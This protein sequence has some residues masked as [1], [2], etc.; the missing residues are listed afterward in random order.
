MNDEHLNSTDLCMEVT[1]RELKVG[2]RVDHKGWWTRVSR[3]DRDDDGWCVLLAEGSGIVDPTGTTGTWKLAPIKIEDRRSLTFRN[4][5]TLTFERTV[6]GHP[7]EWEYGDE[8]ETW[9]RT[10]T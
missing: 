7:D 6:T 3:I 1:T 4:G 5:K 9:G 8:K 2:D 10:L